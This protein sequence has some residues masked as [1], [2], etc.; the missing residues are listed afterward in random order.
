M[1][2]P[3]LVARELLELARRAAPLEACGL[4][5]A[6]DAGRLRLVELGNLAPVPGR[7]L[8]DPGGLHAV[9]SA[10]AAGSESLAAFWHS[11]AGADALPGGSDLEGAWKDVPVLVCTPSA[12]PPWRLWRLGKAGFSELP[13]ELEESPTSARAARSQTRPRPPRT[14]C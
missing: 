7:F 14:P 10:S 11:H 12:M 13:L 2:L 3:A 4:L 6:D 1:L 9:L 5:L 8:V